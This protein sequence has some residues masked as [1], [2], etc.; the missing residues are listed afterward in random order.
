MTRITL[1]TSVVSVLALAVIRAGPPARGDPPPFFPE[2]IYLHGS[3]TYN[4]DDWQIDAD[5]DP[6]DWSLRLNTLGLE[7]RPRN[8]VGSTV[9]HQ[10]FRGA[11]AIDGDMWV[12]VRLAVSDFAAVGFMIGVYDRAADPFTLA[13]T[14]GA[15]FEKTD[16]SAVV[17]WRVRNGGGNPPVAGPTLQPGTPEDLVIHVVPNGLST[18]VQFWWRHAGVQSFTTSGPVTIDTPGTEAELHFSAGAKT[19]AIPGGT[20]TIQVF[21][22]EAEGTANVTGPEDWERSRLGSLVLNA[23]PND[24]TKTDWWL[25]TAGGAT[26][27]WPGFDVPGA[28]H[29]GFHMDLPALNGGRATMQLKPWY[30]PFHGD[31]FGAWRIRTNLATETEFYAGYF[32]RD[33]DP[34]TDHPD[35]MVCFRLRQ[36]AIGPYIE[37]FAKNRTSE[38]APAT[39]FLIE[40]NVD[41]DLALLF[42]HDQGPPV[43]ASFW[44]RRVGEAWNG[45]TVLSDASKLPTLGRYDLVK[46][47]YSIAARAASPGTMALPR[48]TVKRFEPRYASGKLEPCHVLN[49]CVP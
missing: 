36:G 1:S 24:Q 45:P 46:M 22:Y 29:T 18:T 23:D 43:T 42:D 2:S 20:M 14:R 30:W 3:R 26:I 25:T 31:A 4:E 39:L 33:G 41:Y 19:L 21:E 13:P 15:W 10:L 32:S 35:D 47:H 37:A 40:S 28:E 5:G 9:R 12:K 48:L 27:A 8:T 11:K 49:N 34:F 44:W 38:A 6:D 16:D 17:K 7:Y